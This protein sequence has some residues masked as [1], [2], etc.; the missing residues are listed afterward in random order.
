VKWL[1]EDE[2]NHK[3]QPLINEYNQKWKEYISE[4]PNQPEHK[5]EYL[6]LS[7]EAKNMLDGLQ[8]IDTRQF[9]MLEGYYE[10]GETFSKKMN[11][12][13]CHSGEIQFTIYYYTIN[14]IVSDFTASIP[15]RNESGSVFGFK[16]L[17]EQEELL[18]VKG[19]M[20]EFG[21]VEF[22]NKLQEV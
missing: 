17:F 20:E 1:L 11:E 4:V 10:D 3:K 12:I 18:V 6:F 7:D 5:L 8:F 15:K 19:Y 14:N 13:D 22:V 21:A 16:R 2:I 9:T